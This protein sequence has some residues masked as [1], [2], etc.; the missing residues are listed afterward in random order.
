ML[1]IS[2]NEFSTSIAKYL[3]MINNGTDILLKSSK[4]GL[5]KITPA[6]QEYTAAEIEFIEDLKGALN[7]VK[8]FKS[9]KDNF[10]TIL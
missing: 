1:V 6:K 10:K 2:T 5:F 9:G 3:G 7:D 4:E 8:D